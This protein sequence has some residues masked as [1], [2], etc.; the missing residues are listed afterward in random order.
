MV[1]S[2]YCRACGAR[3]P[4]ESPFCPQCGV[5]QAGLEQTLTDM[6]Q[7]AHAIFE[8]GRL[9]TGRMV[10]QKYQ[11]LR[12]LGQGGMG[13]VYT[14][15]DT[16]LGLPLVAIKEM[17]MQRLTQ[18]EIPLA[19][20]VQQ[21]HQEARLLAG[22][23]HPSL[24][25]I[26]E[27]FREDV[28]LYLVMSF[29]EEQTLQAALDTAPEKKLPVQ[30]AV[31][32]G[33]EICKVLDY[34]HTHDPQIIFRNLKP[35]NIM[36]TSEGHIY[37]IGFGIA[38]HFKQEK[39]VDTAYYSPIGYSPIE[40]YS[41][42]QTSL[43]SDIYSLGAIL[44]QMLSGHNPS[45]NPFQFANL[46]IVDPTLPI[47]LTQ[48]ITKMLEMQEQNRPAS[49]IAVQAQLESMFTPAAS[50]PT[51]LAPTPSI[52]L[53]VPTSISAPPTRSPLVSA[54]NPQAFEVLRTLTGHTHHVWSMGWNPDELTLASGSKDRTIKLWDAQTGQLL[55]TL[56]GHTGNVNSLAWN[57]DR[58]TL[59]SSS[60]DKTIK[61]WN[62]QTGQSLHTL[63]GHTS[64]V[65]SVAWNA[66]GQT[67]ASGSDDKTIKLWDAQTGQLLCTLT[68]HTGYVLNVVWSSDGQALASGSEDGTIKLWNAQTGQL[69]RTLGDHTNSVTSVAWSPDGQT[70]ASSSGNGAINLWDAQTGQLL[71]T[72]TGHTAQVL[73]L[74]WN[75]DRQTLASGSLDR[76][77]R[78]WN[79]QTGQL[80]HTLTSHTDYVRGVVWNPDGQMLASGSFDKTIKIWGV[81]E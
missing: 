48:L 60:L 28:R 63:T 22:L 62:A 49:A 43:R 37:L 39:P 69:L 27:Y 16:R 11:V 24:P 74:V 42:A 19:E 13:A 61:L 10:G 31:R 18:Q 32:I 67:L 41:H 59:A 80:L 51:I 44:H 66:N 38:R 8:M 64:H 57:A 21:F 65:F 56:T 52:Q 35:S 75:P 71:C 34:L 68:G 6:T 53:T 36:L 12:V 9:P 58:Q 50:T 77:I 26:H 47:P 79:T 73:S 46:Q 4:A 45:V 70:L 2:L 14:A 29:I 81:R 20:A 54:V 33:I 25:V 5:P 23:H 1:A 40:Q 72:L 17:G 15:Y 30:E 7:P 3:L 76:T 78:L 55:R